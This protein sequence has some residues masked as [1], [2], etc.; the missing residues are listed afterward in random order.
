MKNEENVDVAL[1]E[2]IIKDN[3][4]NENISSTFKEFQHE[5]SI[6]CNVQHPNVVRLFGLCIKPLMM[7]LEFCSRGDLH[8]HLED[9][10]L[11][12]EEL[13]TLQ[14]QLKLATDI[15]NGMCYLH[16]CSP[17]IIRTYFLSL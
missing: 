5:V 11:L 4:D 13:Y 17:P 10:T 6:M 8:R 1:K 14:L 7:V 15:A 3:A 9:K 2:L 12:P 16:S